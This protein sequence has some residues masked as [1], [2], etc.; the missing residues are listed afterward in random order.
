M[1]VWF[2]MSNNT[3]PNKQSVFVVVVVSCSRAR[4]RKR[5]RE[6]SRSLKYTYTISTH[7]CCKFASAHTYT[8]AH[9]RL[10]ALAREL[11]YQRRVLGLF[12]III[13][14]IIV[15]IMIRS[16]L[17]F[18]LFKTFCFYYFFFFYPRSY[19]VC[20][21]LCA[22][23]KRVKRKKYCIGSINQA[24]TILLIIRKTIASDYYYYYTAEQQTNAKIVGFA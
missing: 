22:Q 14:I 13:I 24:S 11:S 18:E 4:R 20:L 8:N 21:F 12:D 7:M 15:I 2:H 23:E 9:A 3:I 6:I 5:E 17:L 16:D 1:C 10:L 19:N